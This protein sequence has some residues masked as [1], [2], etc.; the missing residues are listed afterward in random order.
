MKCPLCGENL[1]TEY[2]K[3]QGKG[4]MGSCCFYC[5]NEDFITDYTSPSIAMAEIESAYKHKKLVN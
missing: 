5:P 2:I 4:K 3:G 1:K